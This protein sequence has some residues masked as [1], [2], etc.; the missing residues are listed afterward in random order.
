LIDLGIVGRE[1]HGQANR[2]FRAD[3]VIKL[4]EAARVRTPTDDLAR[5]E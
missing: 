3:D 5:L 4:F 2:L 1:G